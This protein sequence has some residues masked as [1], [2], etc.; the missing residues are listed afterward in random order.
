[1]NKIVYFVLLF[2]VLVFISGYKNESQTEKTQKQQTIEK[3]EP[4]KEEKTTGINARN[5]RGETK[6]HIAVNGY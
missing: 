1:M 2:F 6:L 3:K 5:E 4:V